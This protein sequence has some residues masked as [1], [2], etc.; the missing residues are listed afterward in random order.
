M[1]SR[2]TR[3]DDR[4]EGWRISRAAKLLGV[5]KHAESHISKAHQLES[6]WLKMFLAEWTIF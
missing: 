6:K 5:T 4:R 3:L 2:L 1:F